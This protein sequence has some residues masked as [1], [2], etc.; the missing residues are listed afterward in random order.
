MAMAQHY[1][2]SPRVV[3]TDLG[4]GTGVL[5]DLDSMFYFTVNATG[6]AV[7]RALEKGIG[8]ADGL[9]EKLASD[10]DVEVERARGDVEALLRELSAERLVRVQNAP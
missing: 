9:A 6:L 10:F 4:D 2:C 8:T 7:W 1:L 3:A 5:L